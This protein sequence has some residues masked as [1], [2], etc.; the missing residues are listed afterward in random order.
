MTSEKA[1]G[2]ERINTWIDQQPVTSPSVELSI[3]VP[4]YNEE[5]RLPPTL[6]DIIDFFDRKSVSYEVLVI[7]D[8]ST[9]GTAEV[10]RKFERVRS[11]VRLIQLPRNYGK[12][13]AV[14]LGVLNCRGSNILFADADGATPIQEFDRLQ[15]AISAGADIAIGSRALASNETKV[16]TSLH[17][18]FLGRVFNKCVNMILLPS[19]ADTQCG[20]KMFSRKAAL[21]L[22]RRQRADRFSF[23]VELLYIAH[24]ANLAIKEVPINWTNVPGSKVNLVLDSLSMFRDV[25]RFKVVH[26]GVD[27]ACF[28]QFEEQAAET[29]KN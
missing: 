7:D 18:R 14:R 29:S 28:E 9:D 12:G 10:V 19:I 4:A 15:A 23:D 8:G 21:F 11:Q 5:R 6:I 24:K 26:R 16:A 25:F 3:V 17:R 20:F 27:R 2:T 1:L 13:H 22:F